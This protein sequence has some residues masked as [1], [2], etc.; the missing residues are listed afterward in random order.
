M[1]TLSCSRA[2]GNDVSHRA[3]DKERKVKYY[4]PKKDAVER[5]RKQNELI[6]AGVK[7]PHDHVGPVE[8]YTI[9]NVDECVQK[10]DIIEG[11]V[12][13]FK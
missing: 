6:A 5:T 1:F 9:K 4:E 10:V 11:I 12:P 8:S 3:R 7:R 13:P 2:Y